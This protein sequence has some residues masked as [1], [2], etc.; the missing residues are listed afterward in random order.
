MFKII[1]QFDYFND[2]SDYN[3]KLPRFFLEIEI[4]MNLL[5]INLICNSVVLL[6]SISLTAIYLSLLIKFQSIAVFKDNNDTD[7]ELYDPLGICTFTDNFPELFHE[8]NYLTPLSL[9]LILFHMFTTKR[10]S[11]LISS[12]NHRRLWFL[13]YI[14][15][16]KIQNVFSKRERL[17][18][19]FGFSII[20][21]H[22][23]TT[24]M[25]NLPDDLQ[26]QFDPVEI[27][28]ELSIQLSEV[29]FIGCRFMPV[30]ISLESK[31]TPHRV[32]GGFYLLL[33]LF[34]S[35]YQQAICLDTLK[36]V[37]FYSLDT[38]DQVN[39]LSIACISLMNLLHSF[40]SSYM[41][42]HLI[43]GTLC[44][45]FLVIRRSMNKINEM[46]ESEWDR[47]NRLAEKKD[48][49]FCVDDLKYTKLL[50]K[51]TYGLKEDY[52]ITEEKQEKIKL[53]EKILIFF[54][55]ISSHA[56]DYIKQYIRSIY[57]PKF[58]FRYSIRFMATQMVYFSCSFYLI[59]ISANLLMYLLKSALFDTSERTYTFN[60]TA[61]FTSYLAYCKIV[62]FGSICGLADPVQDIGFGW[63]WF[64]YL[65]SIFF[66]Y[67]LFL[68]H[69]FQNFRTYKHDL[70]MV[71]KGNHE[72]KELRKHIS[73]A[74]IAVY[75]L[76]N[77]QFIT[78]LLF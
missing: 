71:Y 20:S 30:F 17:F 21:F 12:T 19:S 68:F 57:D 50:F 70:L 56:I 51:R 59:V 2:F 27:L 45:R 29:I 67:F 72:F 64:A 7:L 41:I 43:I 4:K 75:Y 74:E 23:I 32:L 69:F 54:K 76:I 1:K 52:N 78:L 35:W 60:R 11:Y 49:F 39:R 63:I 46:G 9:L 42:G 77:F 18:Y 58:H 65:F 31:R 44:K 55:K 13:N 37:M 28:R 22:L 66:S 16:P 33:D 10:K 15:L 40:F 6:F 34:L 47:L 8:A 62:F 61:N 36:V 5:D 48:L 73:N 24:T 3:K 53:N 25:K 26:F 14:S 38:I